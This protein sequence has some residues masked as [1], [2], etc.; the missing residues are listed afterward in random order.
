MCSPTLIDENKQKKEKGRTGLDLGQNG[1]RASC[2]NL[3]HHGA[4]AVDPLDAMLRRGRKW[5]GV[6]PPSRS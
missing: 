4:T 5:S 3:G 1:P 2:P 6:V